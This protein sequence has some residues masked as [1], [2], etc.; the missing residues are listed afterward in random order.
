MY[1]YIYVESMYES[2]ETMYIYM[3]KHM[4]IISEFMPYIQC[5]IM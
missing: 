2:F 3:I 5:T 4:I 1:I